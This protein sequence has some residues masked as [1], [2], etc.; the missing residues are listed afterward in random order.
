MWLDALM[1]ASMHAHTPQWHSDNYVLLAASRLD[2]NMLF[3][4]LFYHINT[5]TYSKFLIFASKSSLFCSNTDFWYFKLS[6]DLL[7]KKK[8]KKYVK[9][10]KNGIL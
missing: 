3:Y 10:L 5:T 4:S 9:P 1:Y 7:Y 2:K 8:K 6:I